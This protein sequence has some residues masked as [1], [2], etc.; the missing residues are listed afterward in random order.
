MK[1][2]FP[3]AWAGRKKLLGVALIGGTAVAVAVLGNRSGD[4][5]PAPAGTASP[6]ATGSTSADKRGARPALSVTLTRLQPENWPQTMNA[7]GNIAAWQE[8]II[9]PELGNYR[10]TEVRVQVGDTVKKGQVLALLAND[11]ATSERDEARAVVAELEASAGDARSNAERAGEL[12]AKGFYSTQLHNQYQTAAQT[13]AARLAA[14]RARLQAAQLRLDK[15][16]IVAPDHGIISARSATAGSLSQPGQELF[17]LIRGGRLEWRADVPAA[18]LGRLRPGM[19][20][21]LAGPA[22]EAVQGQI[23]TV[24]PVVEPATRNGVVYVDLPATSPLRAGMFARG[25]FRFGHT[26]AQT[27]PQGAVVLREGFA[28]VFRREGEDRVAQTK[29]TTGRRQGDRVEITSGLPANAE[30]VASGAGFLADGDRVKVVSTPPAPPASPV[31]S[32]SH[33]EARP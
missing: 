10:L 31:A 14:A 19:T 30:I 7:N 6:P 13:A 28:Y 33:Q 18:E 25:T 3:G 29:V 17:R 22:G 23:R 9:S 11:T 2:S 32:V 27:L 12:K 20:A 8:A 5:P 4:T 24:G 15:T 26:P 21:N 16:R 1:F